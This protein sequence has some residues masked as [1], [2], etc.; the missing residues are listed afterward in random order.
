VS[1]SSFDRLS[2][3]VNLAYGLTDEDVATLRDTAPPRMP[4]GLE[5]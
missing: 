4:H 3:A 1:N 2:A 5:P